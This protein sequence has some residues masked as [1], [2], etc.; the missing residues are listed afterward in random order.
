MHVCAFFRRHVISRAVL[1][2]FDGGFFKA[3][4]PVERPLAKVDPNREFG[5]GEVVGLLGFEVRDLL[6][7]DE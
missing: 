3:R 4:K 6:L 7:R 1:G 2:S 5:A